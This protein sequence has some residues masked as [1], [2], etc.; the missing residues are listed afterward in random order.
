MRKKIFIGMCLSTLLALVAMIGLL[1]VFFSGTRITP[2][3]VVTS[4][5]LIGIIGVVNYVLASKLA[6][7]ITDSVNQ[8]DFSNPDEI[9]VYD[10]LTSFISTGLNHQNRI[11][12]QLNELSDWVAGIRS[13]FENMHEGFIMLDPSGDIIIANAHARNI[14]DV[15][16]DI[17]GKHINF[18]TRHIDFLDKVRAVLHGYSVQMVIEME[19]VYQISFIPS[20]GLGAIVLISDAT[21]RQLAKKM[22]REFLPAVSHELKAPLTY[23]AGFA[24]MISKGQIETEN[25]MYFAEKIQR[26]AEGMAEAVEN[27]IFLSDLDEMDR[28]EDFRQFDVAKIAADVVASL[29]PAAE[30]AQVELSL[31]DAPCPVYG[32]RRLIR[33]MLANLISNGI[34]YNQ[35]MGQVKMAVSFKDYSA[36]ISVTDT[37]IGIPKEQQHRVFERFYRIEDTKGEKIG[38]AGLGL[39]IVKHIVRYHGGTIELESAPGEGTRVFVKLPQ[40]D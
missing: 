3:L 21:A 7:K 13:V 14:F 27:I 37:G 6:D 33:A 23:I 22:R 25:M 32:N 38:G 4:I 15:N 11:E 39:A 36:Y 12:G 40:G 34:H 20:V 19:Q 17:E 30:A 1:A 9:E 2:M 35:P 24:E 8:I 5:V 18:L 31:A 10:E 26:E 28:G 16:D 29:R